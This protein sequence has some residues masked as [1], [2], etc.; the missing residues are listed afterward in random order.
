VGRTSECATVTQTKF[1]RIGGRR[2]D[3]NCKEAKE[4]MKN[5]EE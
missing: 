5:S 1:G 2:R 3:S 4:D